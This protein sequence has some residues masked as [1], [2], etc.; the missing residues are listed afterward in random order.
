MAKIKKTNVMRILDKQK[1]PYTTKAY[2]YSEDDLSGVHAAAE[3]GMDPEQVFKTLVGQGNKTGI[4]VFCIPSDKELDLKKAA[5]CSG[6]KSLHLLHVKDLPGLT[7]YIRGGCSPIG[8]KKQFPTCI[9]E[10][11]QNYAAISISAGQRGQQVLVA[12]DAV[13][14]LIGAA[15]HDLTM[16]DIVLTEGRIR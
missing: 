14:A 10:S 11:A 9:D 8:M 1:I 6:N 3:L 13:A 4:V 15:F 7:G 5:A 2:N 16:K 12:P